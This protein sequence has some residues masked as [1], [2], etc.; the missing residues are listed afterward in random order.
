MYKE[1]ITSNWSKSSRIKHIDLLEDDLNSVQDYVKNASNITLIGNGRSYSENCIPTDGVSTMFRRRNPILLAENALI[2][3]GPFT[4]IRELWSL[5]EG[6]NFTLPVVPGTG[7]VTVGGA[8]ASDVHG[9]SHHRDGSFGE[10]I[11]K[12]KLINGSGEILELTPKG[13]YSDMFWATVGG[14]G[15]TGIIVEVE[16]GLK[17][18]SNQ[19]LIVAEKRT[20]G[21][22]QTMDDLSYLSQNFAYTA[23]WIDLSS[24]S[25]MRGI[26]T[27][28]FDCND[29]GERNKFP[30]KKYKVS[31]PELPL[32]LIRSKTISMFNTL[33]YNKPLING[34]I[35]P[36]SFHHPLDSLRNWN[37]LFGKKGPIQ[38]QFVVPHSSAEYIEI[39]LKSCQDLGL[40][41]PLVVLKNLGNPSPAF[42]SFPMEGWTLAVDFP[43]SDRVIKFLKGEIDKLI[44]FGGKTYLA[45]DELANA[46]QFKSMY[47]KLDKFLE[48]KR[49]MDVNG[50]FQS[51]LS[52]KLGLDIGK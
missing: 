5:I 13:S 29:F 1:K 4:T 37:N 41:S 31:I 9:K 28:A 36:V 48:V 43:R 17:K 27:Y 23:A 50:K 20:V 22:K 25:K 38:Y 52:H 16:I 8:V 18:V 30:T 3:T 2:S 34:V 14:I 26:I 40:M 10:H 32:N 42:L 19:N 45:K 6:S 49:L 47:P 33:W 46:Q 35:N 21:L 39:F 24:N 44:S 7:M 12:I 11:N 15:L 51:K